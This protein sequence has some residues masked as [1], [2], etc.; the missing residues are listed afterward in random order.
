MPLFFS[1]LIFA[2]QSAACF[3]F[4]SS[5]LAG[6]NGGR[7]FVPFRAPR[8]VTADETREDRDEDD[9]R[10]HY[11][12]VLVYSGN[13]AAQE[14]AN[15]HHAPDPDN[16]ANDVKRYEL[17]EF[18]AADTRHH[19][20]ECPDDWHELGYDD[21]LGCVFRVELVGSNSMLLVEED[22]VFSIEDPGSGD[23]TDGIPN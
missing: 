22:A 1:C 17:P 2:E 14:I 3:L 8:P 7:I 15:P 11:L 16:C 9:D 18:H 13:I 6:F 4:G 5:E 20:R 21:C 12:D 19:G 10:N 23:A